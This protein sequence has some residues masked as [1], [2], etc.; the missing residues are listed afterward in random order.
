MF[1]VGLSVGDGLSGSGLRM[2]KPIAGLS[3]AMLM[4][5]AVCALAPTAEA[6]AGDVR[7]VVA[8]VIQVPTGSESRLRIELAPR[9]AVPNRSIVL[10]KGLP[11]A[12][13]LSQGRLFDSG[14]WGVPVANIDELRVITSTAAVGKTAFSVSLVSLTGDLLAESKSSLMVAP[15]TQ[16]VETTAAV[17]QADKLRSLHDGAEG[18]A[19]KPLPPPLTGKALDYV[20]LCMQKGDESMKAGNIN[21]ARLFY[22]QA[23]DQ[24]WAEGAFALASTYD[25]V[26]LSNMRVMGGIQADPQLAKRWYQTAARLGSQAAEPRLDRLA[27]R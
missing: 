24:G 27:G 10:I 4:L 26:E 2:R 20:K 9:A 3:P 15:A 22:T 16:A 7:I 17:Q 12:I 13:S 8:P 11:S 6:W 19:E 18:P 25:P 14:V 5:A 23:A 21:V 1:R